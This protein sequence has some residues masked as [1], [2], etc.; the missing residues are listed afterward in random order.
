MMDVR[1][2]QRMMKQMNTEEL[3]AESVE[4]RMKDGKTLTIEKP[5]V[6][7][8]EIMG[9]VTW[10]VTGRPVESA[11]GPKQEDVGMVASA[12]GVTEAVAG[13]A[14]EESGGDIAA[15]ILKLKK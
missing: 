15:A 5:S 3:P 4:I 8:M 6:T 11:A 10:Q 14:L 1:N 13:A 9:Q 7:R 2:L 12:A